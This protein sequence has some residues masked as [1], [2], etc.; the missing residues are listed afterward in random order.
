[1]QKSKAQIEKKQP[2]ITN[3]KKKQL[4]LLSSVRCGAEFKKLHNKI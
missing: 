3:I 1:M 4:Y 2:F